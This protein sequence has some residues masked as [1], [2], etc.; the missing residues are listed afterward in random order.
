[1]LPQ[2]LDKSY[3]PQVVEQ[4]WSQF[5]INEGY[6]LAKVDNPSSPYTIVIPPAT[7]IRRELTRKTRTG[8]FHSA[9]MG[10][11]AAIWPYHC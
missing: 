4:R 10:M 11:E 1:M 6:F 7:Q 3:Q 2:Q 5:W 8:C 9:G